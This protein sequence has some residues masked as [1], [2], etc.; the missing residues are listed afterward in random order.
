[1]LQE[2][3]QAVASSSSIAVRGSCTKT[4]LL[5]TSPH[6]NQT[7]IDTTP[8]NGIV[9][10]DPSE[11]L[12][13]AETGTRISSLVAALNENG[14]Y[15][16]FDPV[17]NR[18][19]A[20]LGG[21]IASGISGP[22]RMLYGSLRDFVMEV[23]LID[24]LGRLVRGGGKVVKN[25]AGFDLPKLM[26]GSYGRLGILTEATL[27]VFPKPPAFLTQ[28][29]EFT[30]L[31]VT[32]AAMRKLQTNPLPISAIEIEPES[33]LVVRYAGR[34]EAL[35]VVATRAEQLLGQSA[36]QIDVSD[37]ESAYWSQLSEFT[38][39]AKGQSLI[40]V[41]IS[42]RK[43][44][45]LHQTL[46]SL[47]GI[48]TV[49]YSCGASVAWLATTPAC[50]FAELDRRLTALSLAAVVVLDGESRSSGLQLLGDKSWV[51]FSVRIQQAMDPQHK[52]A[53]FAV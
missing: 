18:A 49:R 27:K 30:S 43:L 14:Q 12:I 11:F 3:C 38:F 41:S 35:G 9:T 10:Y 51:P 31:A 26:V 1:M 16:P 20:T 39:V 15:L 42:G 8:L 19:G 46:Q 6:E 53:P 29:F 44:L 48:E 2:L 22:D 23:Q 21:T 36:A 4:A 25:S 50:D 40:R 24:G 45:A 47:D 28:R 32:L 7:E 13:T 17:L 33:Q 34:A 5:C 37:I 52:F